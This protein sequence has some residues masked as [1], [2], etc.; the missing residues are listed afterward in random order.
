MNNNILFLINFVFDLRKSV[1]LMLHMRW[2]ISKN[3]DG[4]DYKWP[5]QQGDTWRK[6]GNEEDKFRYGG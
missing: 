1:E 3:P 2:N 5:F 6:Q 4:K